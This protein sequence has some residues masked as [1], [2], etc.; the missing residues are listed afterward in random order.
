VLAWLG[1]L[2]AGGEEAEPGAEPAVQRCRH[3]LRV[4]DWVAAAAGGVVVGERVIRCDLL[5]SGL[6]R[7]A[8]LELERARLGLPPA[9][10]L[11]RRPGPERK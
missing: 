2:G 4:L 1:R 6:R 8:S 11:A 10:F 3:R 9:W 7:C 5:R